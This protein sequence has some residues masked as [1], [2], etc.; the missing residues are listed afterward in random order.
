MKASPK[1]RSCLQSEYV[2]IDTLPKSSA[3]APK[4]ASG[5]NVPAGTTSPFQFWKL[6][7]NADIMGEF[8]KNTNIFGLRTQAV[9]VDVTVD[10]LYNFFSIIFSM[11]IVSQPEMR[12]FWCGTEWVHSTTLL[13]PLFTNFLFRHSPGIESE[14][15]GARSV[16]S[17]L[18]LCN[19]QPAR[20]NVG[21]ELRVTIYPL[22]LHGIDD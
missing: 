21:F 19:A 3:S 10:I 4:L 13:R 5:K 12:S 20:E 11:G 16:R 18:R 15:I 22:N 14:G 17:R 9:W 7:F 8:V 6:F 1:K 2:S